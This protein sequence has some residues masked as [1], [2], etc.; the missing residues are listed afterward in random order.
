MKR[1]W[2]LAVGIA[3]WFVLL[4]GVMILRE[5]QDLKV[6]WPKGLPSTTAPTH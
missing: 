6:P 3:L 5:N 4:F 2:I 1:S